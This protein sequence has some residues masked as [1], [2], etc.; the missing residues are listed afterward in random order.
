MT[1]QQGAAAVARVD[2][3]VGLDEPGT[4]TVVDCDRP[5][6]AADAAFGQSNR[7]TDGESDGRDARAHVR[8]CLGQ[9]EQ[10]PGQWFAGTDQREISL[11]VHPD[12]GAGRALPAVDQA[13]DRRLLHDVSHGGDDGRRQQKARADSLVGA[14]HRLDADHTAAVV[15]VQG[16]SR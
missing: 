1:V 3:C 9:G 16:S 5:V 4:G 15:L 12:H 6:E 8:L 2:G 10:V 11:G 7:V 14:A 13:D